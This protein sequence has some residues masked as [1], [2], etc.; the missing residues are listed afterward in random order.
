MNNVEMRMS[1]M[2][3]VSTG[4]I[5]FFFFFQGQYLF[6]DVSPSFRSPDISPNIGFGYCKGSETATRIFR[7]RKSNRFP[8]PEGNLRVIKR[9]QYR[10]IAVVRR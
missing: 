7:N 3:K 10:E 6:F 5:P 1:Q 4:V 8:Q 2:L 9:L